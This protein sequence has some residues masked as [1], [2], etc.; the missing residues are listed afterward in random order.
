VNAPTPTPI[1]RIL[2]V[3]NLPIAERPK[4]TMARA[5]FI[6]LMDQYSGMRYRLTL[7]EIQ[8]L[9]YLLQEAGQPLNLRYVAHLYGPYAHNLNKVLET[10][11][12]HYIRGYA[13]DARPDVEIALLPGAVEEADAFLAAH[14]GA[15]ERLHRVASTIEGFETPYGMELLASV[16]W[17]AVHQNV[18]ATA[19]QAVDA[20]LNW[21]D[22]K[23][24][25]FDPKHIRLAWERLRDFSWLEQQAVP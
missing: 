16:H 11:E 20:M 18:R 22:R 25:L 9:A 13:G 3:D 15:L 12:G 1:Y 19:E 21:N 4:L 10:L 24:D 8:K 14:D 17:L 2:H 23:R 6:R 5:L 7:L